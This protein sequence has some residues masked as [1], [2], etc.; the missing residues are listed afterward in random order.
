MYVAVEA[1]ELQCLAYELSQFPCRAFT[2][3]C[4]TA[5]VSPSFAFD[6]QSLND[7]I[8]YEQ[9]F[10]KLPNRNICAV[11]NHKNMVTIIAP[12]RQIYIWRH[13]Q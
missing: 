1:R 7:F 13:W 10:E 9:W 3:F 6:E 12:P 11:I 5:S 2:A 4:P 8:L